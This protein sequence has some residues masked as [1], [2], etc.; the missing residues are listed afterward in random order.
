ME[1]I[2]QEGKKPRRYKIITRKKIVKICAEWNKTLKYRAIM[3]KFDI[4]FRKV[5]RIIKIILKNEGIGV[6]ERPEVRLERI[7]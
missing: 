4:S 2:N 5:K 3:K 6:F 1:R 7:Y